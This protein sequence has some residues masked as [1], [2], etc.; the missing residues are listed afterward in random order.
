MAWY[1]TVRPTRVRSASPARCRTERCCD[2]APGVTPRAAG[3]RGGRGGRAQRAEQPGAHRA[4]QLRGGGGARLR[5][6]APRGVVGVPHGGGAAR[7]VVQRRLRAG[8]LPHRHIGPAEH[9]RHDH[10]PVRSEHHIV[11]PRVRFADRQHALV[12]VEVGVQ[13]VQQRPGAA[14][15]QQPAPVG[16]V[17]VQ[18]G[19]HPLPVRGDQPVVEPRQLGRDLRQAGRGACGELDRAGRPGH[20]AEHP[21][22]AGPHRLGGGGAQP[23]QF[24]VEGGTADRRGGDQELRV[25][26]QPVDEERPHPAQRLRAASQLRLCPPHPGGVHRGLPRLREQPDRHDGLVQRREREPAGGQVRHPDLKPDHDLA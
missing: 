20:T 5:R 22:Q 11:E 18:D 25:I 14:V 6:A 19:T 3:E 24:G 23:V 10:H 9:A 8:L 4:E 17:G 2:T 15:G 13:V 16:D 1:S 21:P 7:R 12:P 26:R